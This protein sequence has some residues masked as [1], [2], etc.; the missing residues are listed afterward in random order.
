MSDIVTITS[1]IDEI[2]KKIDI[3]YDKGRVEGYHQGRLFNHNRLLA[4]HDKQIREQI[5]D[6][7]YPMIRELGTSQRIDEICEIMEQLKE[8]KNEL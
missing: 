3:A 1:I 5:I 2:N 7:I 4:D 6:E 8:Q